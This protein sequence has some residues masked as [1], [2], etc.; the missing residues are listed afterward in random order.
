MHGYLPWV[1]AGACLLIGLAA[2]LRKRASWASWCFLGGMLLLAVERVFDHRV[3]EAGALREASERLA[4]ALVIRSLVP[5]V[6]LCF[7]LIYARGNRREFLARWRLLLIGTFVVPPLIA[8]WFQRGL[9][10][11]TGVG[12]ADEGVGLLAPGKVLVV[13]LLAA[14]IVILVNLEKT[15]RAS[16]G[17]SR[18]RIKYLFLGAGL[19]F[20]AKVY[21]LSQALLF[22]GFHPGLANVGSV[23]AILGCGLMA[24]GYFR[25]SFG[26]LDIYPS[27]A[28]L[29]GSLTALL[30][31]GYL[32]I[33]GLLAQVVAYLGGVASFPAQAFMVLLGIV[34]LTV[35]LLSDRF[36]TGLQRFV[37]RHFRR[38]Q[39]DFRKVWTAFTGR[40]STVLG[41]DQLGVTASELIS[42]T[43]HVLNVGFFLSDDEQTE[44]RR[45]SSTSKKVGESGATAV[46]SIPPETFGQLVAEGRPFNLDEA[47]GDWAEGLREA[48]P[49]Q[50]EHG[51]DRFAVPLVAGDRLLGLMVLA[52]R[53]N[54]IRYCH[55]ERELLKCI[56]DQ[57]GAALLNCS[58][59]EELM[60]AK[61][62]E[63]FQTLSTFFV[64]DLKNAANSLN[65]MLQNLPVH[66]DDPEFR[67]DAVRGIGSTVDRINRLILKLSALRQELQLELVVTDLNQLVGEVIDGLGT[68]AGGVEVIR[69]L[70]P[71]P[72]IRLDR[73]QMRSVVT[74][75]IVNARESIDGQGVIRVETK[76]DAGRV[77]L[78]VADTGIGMSQEFIRDDLFRPFQSTKSKGLGIGMF[79]CRK[80]VEAHRGTIHTE[81]EPGEGTTFRISLPE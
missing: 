11:I 13:L 17:L 74:N 35:L 40:T 44:L 8:L 23:A 73:E 26:T 45:C 52:D 61:E 56:G 67:A 36:R 6:W 19:I 10:E 27:R 42:E 49:V 2:V 68:E 29:Q 34:G 58:L 59:T 12:G 47:K 55:E 18:W 78:S 25:E 7:S 60:Q 3:L 50:F 79:Q 54:G 28:V 15:F 72:D 75:L 39:Y 70:K 77:M 20:G 57:V 71:L 63:A 16:V 43:F 53:V 65:L 76:R 46:V 41:R 62:L 5:G 9:V 81:S 69:D 66:F 4:D 51:G 21:V 32:I 48:S 30:A 1:A 31:G 24:V 64:H 37:T 14:T 22:S 38:P 80:I 33:V